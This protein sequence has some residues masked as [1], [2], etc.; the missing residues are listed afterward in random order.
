M[1][2]AERNRALIKE[3]YAKLKAGD[4]DGFYDMFAEDAVLHEAESLP[5]GGTWR[6]KAMLRAGVQRMYEA[7]AEMLFEVEEVTAGGDIAIVLLHTSAKGH[8]SG[9]SY[10]FP[11]CELWR[12]RDGKVIELRP[13]YWDTRRALEVWGTGPA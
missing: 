13:F 9:K 2:D 8:S 11:V 10:A 12:F 3:A 6:G 5:Y 7:W 4:E 1:S